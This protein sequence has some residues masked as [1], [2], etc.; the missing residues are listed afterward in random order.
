M[1]P[2]ELERLRNKLKVRY[3]ELAART[4]LPSSYVQKILEGE[5]V[6]IWK[7]VDRIEKILLR[8]EAEPEDCRGSG[9]AF[10]EG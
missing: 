2:Q 8:I 4:G 9:G 7:D 1:T 6:P 5:V 3:V 10:E